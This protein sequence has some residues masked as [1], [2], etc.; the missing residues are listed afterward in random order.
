MGLAPA[1]R[2]GGYSRRS[3]LWE[4]SHPTSKADVRYSANDATPMLVLQAVLLITALA[5]DFRFTF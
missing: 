1:V 2:T 5:P 3:R 4:F